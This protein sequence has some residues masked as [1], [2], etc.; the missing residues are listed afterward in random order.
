VINS[1]E[2]ASTAIFMKARLI[3]NRVDALRKI[4]FEKALDML[5]SGI[6]DK[7]KWVDKNIDILKKQ[8]IK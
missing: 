7:L 5:T 1:S 2:T 8:E 6:E 3:N 4:P